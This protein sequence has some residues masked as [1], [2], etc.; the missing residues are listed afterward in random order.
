M[1][2]KRSLGCIQQTRNALKYI[3]KKKQNREI[4]ERE[5]KESGHPCPCS[6]VVCLPSCRAHNA[7]ASS[8]AEGRTRRAAVF[9]QRDALSGI[10]LVESERRVDPL[11]VCPPLDGPHPFETQPPNVW[12]TLDVGEGAPLLSSCRHSSPGSFSSRH[13]T[14]GNLLNSLLN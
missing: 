11:L 5:L 2:S 6:Q 4:L 1:L 8:A 12:R 14:P 13:N 9:S 7:F 10:V 3:G